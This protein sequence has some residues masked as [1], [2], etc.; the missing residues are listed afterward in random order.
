ML[1]NPSR[2][3][4]HGGHTVNEFLQIVGTRWTKAEDDGLYYAVLS[5]YTLYQTTGNPIYL[6]TSQLVKLVNSMNYVINTKY[7]THHQ[8]FMSQ[9]RGESLMSSSP[10]FGYDPVN[11]TLVVDP[12]EEYQHKERRI[13]HLASLYQNSNMY[14]VLC[15]LI[16][17]LDAA[18]IE[19]QQLS[20]YYAFTNQLKQSLQSQFINQDGLFY[21]SLL[22]FDNDTTLWDAFEEG[23]V[24]EYTWAVTL[25]PFFFDTLTTLRSAYHLYT[26]G[27]QVKPYNYSAWNTLSHFLKEWRLPDKD[28]ETMITSEIDES[29][30]V[31]TKYPM[32]HA[33]IEYQQDLE[34]WRGLPFCIAPLITS[35][36][37]LLLQSLPQ[38]LAV[39]ASMLVDSV[40]YFQYRTCVLHIVATDIGEEVHRWLFAGR[41]IE[42]SL[43]IPERWLV[44]GSHQIQIVRG[45]T[46]RLPRLYSSNARLLDI[47]KQ[48]S[49]I[50]LEF[51]NAVPSELVFEGIE[52]D[53]LHIYSSEGDMLIYEQKSV[54]NDSRS[55]IFIEYLGNFT[56]L[57]KHTQ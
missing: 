37:A 23:D 49:T 9:T 35:V 42:C 17:L 19:H 27:T 8:L 6:D 7:D 28:F 36:T 24:L 51:F 18:Q 4:Q 43:Q 52:Q 40:T 16:I 44:M 13:T 11:G 1:D 29:G 34:G 50:T 25:G 21:S 32:T 22:F 5:L 45:S 20:H 30:C 39:R 33:I 12:P 55:L 53:T 38:G 26:H 31:T 15:M 3:F 47:Y 46:P 54:T 48:G 57:I 2:Q 56:I 10:L 41:T 14:N